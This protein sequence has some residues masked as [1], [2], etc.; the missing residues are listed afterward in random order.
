MSMKIGYS[1]EDSILKTADIAQKK[2]YGALQKLSTGLQINSAADD[3]AG[4][5]LSEKLNAET[6]AANASV[7]NSRMEQAMMSVAESDLSRVSENN[8]RMRDLTVQSMNGTYGDSERAMMQEEI[9]QLNSENERIAKSSDFNGKKLLD[10]SAANTQVMRE[11]ESPVTVKEGFKDASP[12]ALGV[13][14]VDIS[15]PDKAA[16]LLS[17]IDQA[18]TTINTRRSELGTVSKALDN[19]IEQQQVKAENLIA[20]N[21]T[22]RDTDVAKQMSEAVNAKILMSAAV[23]MQSQAN[24]TNQSVMGLLRTSSQ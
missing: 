16:Q 9:N 11:Q 22:I 18:Q 1:L 2:L 14:S 13:D 8:Q 20:A 12:T 15:S 6:R 3:A 21:S 19:N 24:S 4:L 17:K 5:A 10:G 7:S 23:A